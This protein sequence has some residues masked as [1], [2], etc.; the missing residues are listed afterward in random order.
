[1]LR[2][3]LALV[4]A[5]S[6]VACGEAAPKPANPS[7]AS[8]AGARVEPA[9]MEIGDGQ[10]GFKIHGDGS[11][12]APKGGRVGTLKASGEI[13]N[14]EG[15]SVV[16][17]GA[18]GRVDFGPDGEGVV[19]TI[20]DDGALTLATK[21]GEKFTASIGADGVVSGTRPSAG[22]LVVKGADT[23]AKKRAVMLVLLSVMMRKQSSGSPAPVV[24]PPPATI[25]SAKP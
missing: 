6:L 23:P 19:A 11:I 15:K 8:A 13:V 25:S 20:T 4:F 22:K 1:M 14:A 5:V 24:A 10:D 7:G 17:L 16:T 21:D 2:H 18:D 9:E 3:T 12:E